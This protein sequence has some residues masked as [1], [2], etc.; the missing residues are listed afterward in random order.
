MA[1]YGEAL[2][3]A[4]DKFC[5]DNIDELRQLQ[6]SNFADGLARLSRY[7]LDILSTELMKISANIKAQLEDR[8]NAGG[9]TDYSSE[10]RDWLQSA[11]YVKRIVAQMLRVI[12]VEVSRRK[13]N[14]ENA[15]KQAFMDVIYNELGPIKFGRYTEMA[16]DL[17]SRRSDAD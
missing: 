10:Y 13:R 11:N 17:L 3:S 16:R 6:I 4:L 1:T 14:D 9:K 5:V 7:E 15:F 12:G 8:Y 2:A